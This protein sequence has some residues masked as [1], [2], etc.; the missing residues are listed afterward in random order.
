MNLNP[1]QREV[2]RIL[3][4]YGRPSTCWKTFL[5]KKRFGPLRPFLTFPGARVVCDLVYSRRTKKQ[6]QADGRRDWVMKNREGYDTYRIRT[7]VFQRE[8]DVVVRDLVEFLKV[9]GEARMEADVDG[10]QRDILEYRGPWSAQG[11]MSDEDED[12]CISSS[13]EGSRLW[14]SF[15]SVLDNPRK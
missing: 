11:D 6:E 3:Q 8:P 15:L 5:I 14:R 1:V 10:W 13:P 12:F 2:I 7:D 9:R 4:D